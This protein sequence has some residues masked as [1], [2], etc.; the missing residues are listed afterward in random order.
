MSTHGAFELTCVCLEIFTPGSL[1]NVPG[2]KRRCSGSLSFFLI[3]GE[4][5][6]PQ[7]TRWLPGEDSHSLSNSWP[8]T[9][10]NEAAGIV[11]PLE[12]AEP[13]IFRQRLQW[14]FVT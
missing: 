9:N 13:D 6:L 14:Q 8:A 10:L 1:S 11:A 2:R 5:H 12:K 3:V 4:P 7:K